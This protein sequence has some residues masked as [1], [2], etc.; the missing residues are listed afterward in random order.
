MEVLRIIKKIV[1]VKNILSVFFG[2][3]MKVLRISKKIV[4]R[5]IKKIV[6]RISKKIVLRIST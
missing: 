2:M 3:H 1:Y 6:L 5:I 4:L